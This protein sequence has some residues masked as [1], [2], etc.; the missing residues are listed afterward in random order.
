MGGRSL[1]VA[2]LWRVAHFTASQRQA[3]PNGVC[4]TTFRIPLT[5]V[6]AGDGSLVWHELTPSLNC[7]PGSDLP[8][9]GGGGGAALDPVFTTLAGPG[10]AL[11]RSSNSCHFL[12]T[13][14]SCQ[15]NVSWSPSTDTSLNS[16][17]MSPARTP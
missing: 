11:E 14:R 6:P 15:E 4:D 3:A 5:T 12:V 8:T 2:A 13:V 16:P 7:T 9:G 1:T 17:I 10:S